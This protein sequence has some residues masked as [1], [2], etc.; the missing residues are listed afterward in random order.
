MLMSAFMYIWL[1][2]SKTHFNERGHINGSCNYYSIGYIISF[3]CGSKHFQKQECHGN[4]FLTGNIRRFWLVYNY[5][6]PSLWLP[7]WELIKQM[8]THKKA[9]RY[10]MEG[11]FTFN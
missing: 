7:R 4:S 9:F 10:E 3:V 1:S 6:C 8:N 2:G 11:F 5:D